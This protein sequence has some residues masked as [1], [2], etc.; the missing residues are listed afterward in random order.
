MTPHPISSIYLPHP[1][2][3]PA[4]IDTLSR[5]RG[6]TPFQRLTHNELLQM[7]GRAGRRGYDTVGHCV[8][9][10]GRFEGAD[11]AFEIISSGPEALASQ[12]TAGYGMVLNVLA[13]RTLDEA[14]AF[15]ERSFGSYLS[16]KGLAARMREVEGLEQEAAE[17]MRRLRKKYK[18]L[19]AGVGGSEEAKREAR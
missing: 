4:V 3:P 8:L 11:E 9:V 6:A 16:G 18:G 2:H 7:A 13:T 14:R 10:Q 5:R 12:F 19:G 17:A 1:P 15:L